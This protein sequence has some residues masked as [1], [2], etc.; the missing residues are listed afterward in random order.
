MGFHA[1]VG[2]AETLLVEL[3]LPGES[4]SS[5]SSESSVWSDGSDSGLGE[6]GGKE[7][8]L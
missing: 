2:E 3:E 1:S 6:P 8:S 5:E 7:G 4:G